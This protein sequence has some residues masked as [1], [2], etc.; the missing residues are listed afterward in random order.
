[1]E[2]ENSFRSSD[3]YSSYLEQITENKNEIFN[4][5]I[6]SII[7]DYN[8]NHYFCTNCKKFPFIKFCKDRK[9]VRLTC[10]CYNNKKITF[11]ELFKI[12]DIRNSEAIFSPTALNK[13]IENELRCKEH[14]KKFKGFSKFFLNNYCEACYEY[15]Y[16]KYY[17]DIIRFDEISID[18]KKIEELKK[19]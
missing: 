14:N 18:K 8:Y 7:N 16:G 5:K 19:K 13:N 17:K 3:F 2:E 11:T 6:D 4:T 15:L 1:M 9:N 12:I 10:S